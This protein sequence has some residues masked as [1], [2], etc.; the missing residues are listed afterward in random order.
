[1]IAVAIYFKEIFSIIGG[2]ILMLLAGIE[3][4]RVRLEGMMKKWDGT[5]SNEGSSNSLS[6]IS[7]T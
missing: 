2:I 1:M 6:E 3:W 7:S 5:E 4:W